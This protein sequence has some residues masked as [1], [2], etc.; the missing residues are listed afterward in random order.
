[1]F[2]L[3]LDQLVDERGGGGE[4]HAPAL[5]AG[6]DGEAGGEMAFAGAGIADQEH[7]LGAFEVAAFGQGTDTGR[8]DVRRL[9]EVELFER[10]DPGQ[11]RLLHAQFDRPPFAVLDL[12]LQQGFEVVQMRVVALGGLFGE[13]SE[14]SSDGRESQRLRVLRDACGVK[15]C[16]VRA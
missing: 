15:A 5:T 3:G 16:G 11:M 10:L 2:A 13:R 9:C 4:A 12:G 1:M 14:L 6:G 7:W 8:R